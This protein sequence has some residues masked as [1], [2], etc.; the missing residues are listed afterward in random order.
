MMR[1]TLVAFV[2]FRL[3]DL[4]MVSLTSNVC[5]GNERRHSTPLEDTS[6]TISFLK[7]YEATLS[8]SQIVF[9]NITKYY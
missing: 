2:P 9:H 4:T 8:V 3:P 7:F 5:Y 1:E 6:Y